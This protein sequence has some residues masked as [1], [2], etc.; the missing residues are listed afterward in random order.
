MSKALFDSNIVID[1]LKALPPAV[2]ELGR[3]DEIA[4]SVMTWIEVMTGARDGEDERVLRQALAGY[5]RIELDD[6]VAIR[7]ARI[8]RDRR[9]KLPDAIIQA[10]AEAHG[11]LLVT[12]NEKDFP[13]GTPG[14]R[15]PYR[16]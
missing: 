2:A 15:V 9:I 12:R 6:D 11:L 7:A 1:L 10:T 8:R 13:E 3:Y 14:V 4:I 5:Q 16:V